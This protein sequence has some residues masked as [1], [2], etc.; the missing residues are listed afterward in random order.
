MYCVWQVVKTPTMISN[1]RVYFRASLVLATDV[2]FRNLTPVM[3]RILL[4]IH[5]CPFFFPMSF[6]NFLFTFVCVCE[7]DGLQSRTY[8]F[9]FRADW[10]QEEC[11]LLTLKRR[12]WSRMW[13]SRKALLPVAHTPT[14]SRN[15]YLICISNAKHFCKHDLEHT[16]KWRCR[17]CSSAF[18]FGWPHSLFG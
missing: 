1:N 6:V 17:L 4:C 9:C 14:G 11:C 5:V 16:L 15:R 13:K 7:D 2:F 12:W 10:N 3:G 8:L 18:G